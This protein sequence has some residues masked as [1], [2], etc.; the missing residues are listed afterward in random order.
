MPRTMVCILMLLVALVGCG[1]SPDGADSSPPLPPIES[2]EQTEVPSEPGGDP[3]PAESD[4]PPDEEGGGGGVEDERDIEVA[5]PTLDNSF[6]TN[7]FALPRVGATSCVVFT[8][9][10]ADVPV[11]VLSV[12]LVDQQPPDDPGLE[13]GETPSAHDQC[14]P[15][16]PGYPEEV[17]TIVDHCVN[18]VLDPQERTGCPV[19]VRSVGSVG[20][21]YTA[22][23]LLQ[24]RATCT[25]LS[26]EPCARLTGRADPT[27]DDPVTVTWTET[28]RYCSCLVERERSGEFLPEEGDGRCPVDEPSP[29]P[30]SPSEPTADQEPGSGEEPGSDQP[31]GGEDSPPPEGGGDPE[32]TDPTSDPSTDGSDDG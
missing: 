17:Q 13:L 28:R 10:R 30:A 18:A 21:D 12:R 27:S 2:A 16:H 4:R 8:N 24:L 14:R 15:S 22:I 7:P 5:G 25:S 3:V 1:G 6:P 9:P 29:A 23:L 31:D 11:T 19:E 32:V 20:T 26:G